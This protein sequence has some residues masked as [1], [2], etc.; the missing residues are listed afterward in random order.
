MKEELLCLN[1]D[2]INRYGYMVHVVALEKSLKQ[3]FDT[4]MPLLIGHDFH[5]TAGW[6]YPFGLFIEPGL[7]RMLA[8][9]LI[10][11]DAKEL[12]FF[13]KSVEKFLAMGYREHFVKHEHAFI[14]LVQGYLNEPHQRVDSGCCAV[15]NHGVSERIFPEL[16]TN[17]DKNGLTAL[18]LLLTDFVYLGQGI[19]QHNHSPLAVYAHSYFRRS[20][21]RFNNFRFFF[22]DALISLSQK[23]DIN[24][25]IR[26]DK[27][28]VGYG[29]SFH[30]AGELEYH[31]GPKYTDDIAHI[32]AGIT[33]HKCSNEERRFSEISTTEFYWKRDENQL[34]FEAE[35]L[36]DTPS[37]VNKDTFHC[38]Y[39]HSIYDVEKQE[40]EH[41]DGA[42]RSYNYESMMERLDKDFLEFGRKAEYKKLFRLDG[43][44]PLHI[45]K[46]LITHYYQGNP[47]IYE[48]FGLKD[49]NESF[50]ILEKPTTKYQALIPYDISKEEGLRL[51][52]SYH[53]LPENIKE[54]RHVDI[55][56]VMSSQ[57]GK[58]YCL[59][60]MVYEVKKMIQHF[61]GEL[62]IPREISLIKIDDCY[63]NIPSI[64]HY[65]DQAEKDLHITVTAFIH[66]FERMLEYKM[67]K[68]VSLSLAFAL[69]NRV[70]RI[71]SYGHM[72]NQLAW[73]Q[74]SFPL[75]FSEEALT[76][77]VSRQREYLNR[78]EINTETLLVGALTQKDGVLYAKRVPINFPYD[79]KLTESG[80]EFHL[81]FP[82]KEESKELFFKGLIKPALCSEVK[83][84]I[85]PD[86]G[87][88]YFTSIRSKMSERN[89]PVHIVEAEALALYWVKAD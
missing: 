53:N 43:K 45:W 73:L 11:T 12:Q 49:E 55:L 27:D 17:V 38:R 3:V 82:E 2:A 56:D 29:P 37:P 68:V 50:K 46:T 31:W 32:K 54:G 83:K 61:G 88:D 13:G 26:L 7:S 16:F 79:L 21:S 59:E 44:I 40:F 35:E 36:T 25:R 60:H 28:M 65:G 66:L 52:I 10:A 30:E 14:P 78:Y 34:I 4:G 64:M 23:K 15:I 8:R 47:L 80:Q 74:N 62:D 63:W 77:W 89:L 70:V 48:Y 58:V 84:A 71:S 85:W 18:S 57:K 6:T 51:L 20:Q 81:R 76:D 33:L 19:F 39:V 9:K 75:I 24:V 42:M 5:R 67:Q 87:E 1:S 69:N 72:Q 41:F 86:T 22:L